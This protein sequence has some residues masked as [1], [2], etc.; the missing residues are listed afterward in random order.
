MALD[1]KKREAMLK[2]LASPLPQLQQR[3]RHLITD[4]DE[5]DEVSSHPVK[6]A[7]RKA[8]PA[9]CKIVT[10]PTP[11]AKPVAPEVI[12]PRAPT[13]PPPQPAPQ[14]SHHDN[15]EPEPSPQAQAIQLHQRIILRLTLQMSPKNKKAKP[16]IKLI[17]KSLKPM[18][19]PKPMNWPL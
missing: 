13:P 11:I 10:L 19:K 14:P 3:K 9:R 15:F 7:A 8:S 1:S 6:K 2:Q 4:V 16:R 17:Q 12:P 18:Q 5:A